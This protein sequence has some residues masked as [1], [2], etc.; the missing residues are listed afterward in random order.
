MMEHLKII[1]FAVLYGLLIL[2][3][4]ERSHDEGLT[5]D[6]VRAS[7]YHSSI[8]QDRKCKFENFVAFY[9][10]RETKHIL[11]LLGVEVLNFYVDGRLLT[12]TYLNNYFETEPS[13]SQHDPNVISI[14]YRDPYRPNY[15]YKVKCENNRELF[16]GN[17]ALT[18]ENNC[19][20][21]ELEWNH[22]L[23]F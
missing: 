20:T 18:P 16:S 19:K 17:L 23:P 10:N 13:C 8:M 22:P 9:W 5:C 4:T 12:N 21:I 14:T 2:G 11:K 3:C 7:N 15:H 6:D 1:L